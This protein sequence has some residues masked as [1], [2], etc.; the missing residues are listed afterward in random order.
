[1]RSWFELVILESAAATEPRLTRDH[2]PI[3]FCSHSLPRPSAVCGEIEKQEGKILE[4]GHEFLRY[5]EPGNV[6]GVRVCAQHPDWENVESEGRLLVKMSYID[7]G[8]FITFTNHTAQMISVRV[9]GTDEPESLRC[10]E[11]FY[12]ILSGASQK[13]QRTHI[14]VAFI[15]REDN[16][17]SS[18]TVVKPGHTYDTRS[19]PETPP[20]KDPNRLTGT[21]SVTTLPP[22]GPARSFATR[23]ELDSLDGRTASF[24]A[25]STVSLIGFSGK[26]T[27][28]YSVDN[29]LTGQHQF[30]GTV[31]AGNFSITLDNGVRM[32]GTITG[33]FEKPV[34]F[35]GGGFW[36]LSRFK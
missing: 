4:R 23:F 10:S 24:T 27:L 2:K 19:E 36:G 13:W 30:W 8:N 33:G 25:T 9:T 34:P 6:I 21:G 28:S 29:D 12:S 20:D 15:L 32:I 1:L 31:G 14:Q 35:A 16:G 3:T 26:V 7:T 5:L 22:D 17:Q 18:M 11:M